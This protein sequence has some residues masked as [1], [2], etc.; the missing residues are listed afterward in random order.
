M[1]PLIVTSIL[2]VP[3]LL[4]LLIPAHD[5]S[6]AFDTRNGVVG[7]RTRQTMASREAWDAA[8]SWARMPMRRSESSPAARAAQPVS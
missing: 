7:I 5:E 2:T 8:H 6:G 3:G 1:S 4:L